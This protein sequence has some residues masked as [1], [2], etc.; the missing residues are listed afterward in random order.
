[1]Y[2]NYQ[3]NIS[4][5]ILMASL[6]QSCGVEALPCQVPSEPAPPRRYEH[7]YQLVPRENVVDVQDNTRQD[8]EAGPCAAREVD[9]SALYAD[10]LLATRHNDAPCKINEVIS[11]LERLDITVDEK[12]R[13]AERYSKQLTYDR[14]TEWCRTAEGVVVL[15][16]LRS[17][18]EVYK[19]VSILREAVSE[20]AID[21][22][23]KSVV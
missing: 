15:D 9:G 13:L 22:D 11:C 19:H 14:G 12:V 10:L 17:F 6:V 20:F 1:M 7:L 8:T 18:T 4:R 21:Q 3:K 23:R 5:I 2:T 16:K